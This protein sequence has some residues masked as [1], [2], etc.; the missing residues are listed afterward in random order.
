M[1]KRFILAS[2]A[3]AFSAAVLISPAPVSD[4]QNFPFKGDYDKLHRYND[5]DQMIG[6]IIKYIGSEEN[7]QVDGNATGDI[8]LLDGDLGSEAADATAVAT[9]CGAV[10]GTFDV[11]DADC[12][13][14]GEL[15][16]EINASDGG[17]GNWIATLVDVPPWADSGASA[18]IMLDPGS[19][20]DAKL[21]QGYPM[22][23]DTTALDDNFIALLPQRMA[24]ADDD[25][26]NWVRGADGTALIDQGELW[27][28]TQTF[29]EYV[30]FIF[31]DA[32]TG[33]CTLEFSMLDMDG[34]TANEYEGQT[35]ELAYVRLEATDD[36]W[37]NRDFL[38][39]P[40]SFPK[41]HRVWVSIA[42]A[43]NTADADN[44]L[45][46]NYVVGRPQ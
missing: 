25:M 32:D 17:G 5:D 22:L 9:N 27:G 23:V 21:P 42:Q 15:M 33:T 31:G 2:I 16:H 6:L 8:L 24:Y 20:Q 37:T 38:A 35:E 29:I 13:T 12:D 4:A 41:G 45:I 3:L 11:S 14:F 7:G 19:P 18:L 46:V 28:D 44:Q 1:V 30:S 40:F 10:A 36:T 39:N 26:R 43:G 34:V